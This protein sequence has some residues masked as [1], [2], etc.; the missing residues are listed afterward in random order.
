MRWIVLALLSTI[1][2]VGVSVFSKRENRGDSRPEPTAIA[3]HG[4]GA[5]FASGVVE[6]RQREVV[7]RFEI[8]GRLASVPVA[9]G[10]RV[11]AGDVLARLDDASWVQD[12]AKANA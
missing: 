8:T 5:I 3:S 2:V 10:N 4:A 12:L 9:E 6:G 11:A 7:L 1:C